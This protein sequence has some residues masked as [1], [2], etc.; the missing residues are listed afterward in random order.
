VTR[1]TNHA[2]PNYIP[3]IALFAVLAVLISRQIQ[4]HPV[5]P[6][7]WFPSQFAASTFIIL[8]CI[9]VA[10]EL[11]NNVLSKKNS[12]TAIL[13]RG[14]F[15]VVIVASWAAIFAI[16]IIR[17]FRIGIFE[18]TLQYIG[19]I[20]FG[21]GIILREWAIYVL[22][23]HFTI[24]VQVRKE[25]NLI[26]YGPYRI[27]RHPSYT[28]TLLTMVGIA[29]AAG[30]WFG[31]LFALVLKLIAYRYRIN[32]EEEALRQAFGS[33]WDDYKKRTWRLIPGF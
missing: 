14:S 20:L 9:W 33:E 19:F 11:V 7:S 3:V 17:S 30:T 29:I 24:R 16:F 4:G 1:H 28:G 10:C 2:I 31:A 32:V 23:K 15:R 27:V 21:A 8:F 5:F 13:D 18:G 25:A 12:Q 22:G 26:T 6:N